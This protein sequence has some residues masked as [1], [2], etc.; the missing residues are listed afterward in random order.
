MGAKFDLKTAFALG[1]AA[2]SPVGFVN[3]ALASA[4][5]RNA[6]P[7]Y[8]PECLRQPPESIRFVWPETVNGTIVPTI[9]ARPRARASFAAPTQG[10]GSDL[11]CP[12]VGWRPDDPVG[13][14]DPAAYWYNWLRPD[15]AHFRR[16]LSMELPKYVAPPTPYAGGNAP[17]ALGGASFAGLDTFLR[18]EQ[19]RLRALTLEQIYREQ[20]GLGPPVPGSTRAPA[21]AVG[22]A[23]LPIETAPGV[24][25][26][27]ETYQFRSLDG[28]LKT[29]PLGTFNMAAELSALRACEGNH[30]VGTAATVNCFDKLY[31]AATKGQ[32]VLGYE[33][34][35]GLPKSPVFAQA[36]NTLQAYN[37]P[38]TPY[39]V[40]SI[41]PT[42]IAAA[43]ETITFNGQQVPLYQEPAQT[44][45]LQRITTG[46]PLVSTIDPSGGTSM[47][48]W[49]GDASPV[50]FNLSS[51]LPSSGTPDI[52]GGDAG[53]GGF[54]G[55]L[56]QVF[57]AV[58][59]IV[60]QLAQ[61]GVIRG[62]VGQALAP[63]L[64][65]NG[66]NPTPVALTP[67]GGIMAPG[68][69]A[70]NVQAIL[71]Q[72][73]L[74]S[75]VP[76]VLGPAAGGA[77]VAEGLESLGN[78]LFSGN[79]GGGVRDGAALANKNGRF[80]ARI[81]VKAPNG[82][83]YVFANLGPATRGKNEVKVMRR[84]GRDNGYACTRGGGPRRRRYYRRRPR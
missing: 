17:G 44:I 71:Q 14:G 5:E 83:V 61:A 32:S 81:Q 22:A 47:S 24:S 74:L 48:I 7:A 55:S 59:P 75:A 38:P 34:P 64:Y 29:I 72:A 52:V 57:G 20:F 69:G 78:Y 50:G 41:L 54:L 4:R 60:Q 30:G 79:G 46:V 15:S 80:N 56:G 28:T 73:G 37:V 77:I 53:T 12:L 6:A 23:P 35:L 40:A 9:A 63:Q 76:R 45:D 51:S 65:N 10:D 68:N 18:G 36:L 82:T 70:A 31:Q 2:L 3:V 58:A 8:N 39:A 26:A 13:D 19:T 25:M 43:P 49:G 21:A 11:V 42:V 27:G 1:S 62:S 66:I 33:E 67:G 84:I 16:F